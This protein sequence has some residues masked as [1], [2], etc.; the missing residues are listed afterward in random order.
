[1]FSGELSNEQI[2]SCARE[3]LSA[4]EVQSISDKFDE[5]KQIADKFNTPDLIADPSTRSL[6]VKARLDANRVQ[7]QIDETTKAMDSADEAVKPQWKAKLDDLDKN[8]E[9]IYEILKNNN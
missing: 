2:L 5:A 6:A 8:V 9:T 4:E 3:G 7:S 1:M